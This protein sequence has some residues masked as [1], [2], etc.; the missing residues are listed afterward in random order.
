MTNSNPHGNKWSC[1]EKS[2]FSGI[3]SGLKEKVPSTQVHELSQRMKNQ[4]YL[5]KVV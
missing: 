2:Y 3:G 1:S 4:I 5:E